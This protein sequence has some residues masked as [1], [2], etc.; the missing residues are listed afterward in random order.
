MLFLI[1]V[2][3]I[4]CVFSILII[5]K[6]SD[7]ATDSLAH[8]AKKLKT[9]YIA[10]GLILVSIMVSLPEII[11]AVYT[12]LLGHET[13]AMGV[14]IG[15]V[16]CNI[17]LMTGISAMIKPLK[18]SRSLILRDG[19]FAVSMAIMVLILSA[20]LKITRAEGLAFLLIFIPYLINVWFEEKAKKERQKEE[21]LKEVQIELKLMGLEFGKIKSGMWSFIIG[22][23]AL[24]F[25]SYIFSVSLINIANLSNVSELLIGLTLGAIGTS[26]PNIVSAVK[27]TMKNIEDIAVSETLGSDIFTLLVSLGIL[28]MIKPID[29][30]I[31]WL[32]F[33]IPVMV[34]MSLLMLIFMF[35]KQ[36]ITRIHGTVLFVSYILFLVVNAFLHL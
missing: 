5:D 4:L 28:S 31:G 11:I 7:W 35:P 1:F 10:V 32:R 23:A 24:L 18:V 6:G 22:M 14:I 26:I 20:D 34:G 12:T 16:I 21:E 25:G 33:D 19:I 29:I 15:S 9:T 27:G 8:V 17:G 3:L 36:R 30:A 13:L 2:Y